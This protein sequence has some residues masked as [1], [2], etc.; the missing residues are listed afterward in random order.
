MKLTTRNFGEIEVLEEKLI[1][2]EEGLPGFEA[3]HKFVMIESEEGVF[4]YL[5]SVED[6]NVCFVITDPYAFFESY[7]PTISEKYFEKLGGGEDDDFAIYAVVCIKDPLSESTINLAGPLLIQ[8]EY[9][10]AIQVITE[11]KQ[12]SPRQK[13]IK[14]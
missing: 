7:A 1:I 3:L 10:K 12:Y 5:Q 4:H 2:F 6:T 14:K 9:K 13:L 8:T 11:D